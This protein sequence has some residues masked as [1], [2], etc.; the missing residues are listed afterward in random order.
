MTATAGRWSYLYPP[1]EECVCVHAD[2]KYTETIWN[3]DYKLFPDRF[4]YSR[5][6]DS[7][8]V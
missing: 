8:N 5:L 3:E 2:G 7:S 1:G 6:R 4:L